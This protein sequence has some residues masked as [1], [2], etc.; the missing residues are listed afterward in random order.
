M[1][2]IDDAQAL[3]RGIYELGFNQG[4]EAVFD[5][6]YAPNFVHHSKVIH[7]VA[8]AGEGEKQ[9]MIRFRAAIPDVQF[10][11]IDMVGDETRVIARLH[12]HGH[13]EQPYGTVP[14]GAYNVHAVAWFRVESQGSH[15]HVAE[16]WLFVDAAV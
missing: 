2:I 3:V 6:C 16:E 10:E 9:S 4:V 8:P 14:E 15:L 5:E 13:A 7:D 1:T 12:I 11:I